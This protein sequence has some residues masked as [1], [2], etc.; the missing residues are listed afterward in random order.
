[1]KTTITKAAAV[2]VAGSALLAMPGCLISSS[3]STSY[4]GAHVTPSELA[5]VTIGESTPDM[6]ESTVGAP[7]TKKTLDD[8]SELWTWNYSK[9]TSG[10]GSV[11]LL[12]SG[13]SSTTNAHSAHV[14]FRDGV[15]AKKWRD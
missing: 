7:S 5:S 10:H 3:N 14:L 13:S 2:L 11:L 9:T 15:A 8:G 4:S 1:M 6:V 12:F